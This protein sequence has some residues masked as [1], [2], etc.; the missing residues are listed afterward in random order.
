MYSSI[1]RHKF[2]PSWYDV[3]NVFLIIFI[4]EEVSIRYGYSTSWLSEISF[5]GLLLANAPSI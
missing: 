4:S 2:I 1:G 5:F 3:P